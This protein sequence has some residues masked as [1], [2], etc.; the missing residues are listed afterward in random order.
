MDQR[1][2]FLLLLTHLADS[3]SLPIFPALFFFPLQLCNEPAAS[4]LRL[5]ADTRAGEENSSQVSH[6]LS[7]GGGR[8]WVGKSSL[9]HS[10]GQLFSFL[11]WPL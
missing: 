10:Q 5:L 1:E 8:R 7:G 3:S 2:N 11:I 9:I 6:E 4:S